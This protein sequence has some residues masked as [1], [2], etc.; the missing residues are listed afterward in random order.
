MNNKLTERK[1]AT[2]QAYKKGYRVIDNEVMYNGNIRKLE[3]RPKKGLMGQDYASFGIRI[4]SGKRIN[5]FVHQLVAYEKFGDKFIN[6]DE[7]TVVIHL[8]GNTLNNNL[9]NIAIGNRY[10]VSSIRN[11]KNVSHNIIK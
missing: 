8:D 9:D 3:V 2:I 10:E 11:G 6:A 7:D 4:D 1:N 5:V